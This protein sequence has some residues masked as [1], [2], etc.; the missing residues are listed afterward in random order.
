MD[1]MGLNNAPNC[2]HNLAPNNCHGFMFR[3]IFDMN[4]TDILY[5]EIDD[6]NDNYKLEL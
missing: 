3:F 6:L 4:E 5:P 2:K 1:V